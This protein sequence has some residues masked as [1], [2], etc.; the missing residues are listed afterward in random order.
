MPTNDNSIAQYTKSKR[1]NILSKTPLRFGASAS[2]WISFDEAGITCDG[3]CSAIPP[4]APPGV[5]ILG[6]KPI[7]QR[8][9]NGQN[10]VF[11]NPNIVNAYKLTFINGTFVTCSPGGISQPALWSDDGYTWSFSSGD[12]SDGRAIASGYDTIN[13]RPV[14][15]IARTDNNNTNKSIVYSIDQGRTF[16]YCNGPG[17]PAGVTY[18]IA[19]GLD[20]NGDGIFVAA[21]WGP[22]VASWSNDGI[23]W[24]SANV[25][26][27]FNSF[28]VKYVGGWWFI[29]DQTSNIS[30]TQTPKGSWVTGSANTIIVSFAYGLANG[31]TPTYLAL[32]G[33]VAPKVF[34]DTAIP[35]TVWQNT[36]SNI[37][38]RSVFDVVYGKGVFVLVGQ[39]TGNPA[40]TQ[41]IQWSS[42]GINWNDTT[43]TSFND[44][45]ARVIFVNDIF[46][47]VGNSQTMVSSSD[48][49]HWVA[50]SIGMSG[51]GSDI[52]F[53]NG[54]YV[55]IGAAIINGTTSII[56]TF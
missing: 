39:K 42:D 16:H 7:A 35:P 38:I 24:T 49:K 11:D 33:S 12:P 1:L 3:T 5:A 32:N 55:V 41:T 56:N 10:I 9:A 36:A 30:T 2:D 17:L 19:Y 18:E 8:A 50:P 37:N 21:T 46:I 53:G 23:T 54:R 51:Q 6:D 14:I 45:G 4:P 31:V 40:S 52:A 25:A 44:T 29:G 47:A 43:G 15:V 28:G 13:N 48:G 26:A 27:G 20:S 22:T 34:F